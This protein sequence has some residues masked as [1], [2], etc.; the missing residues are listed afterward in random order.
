MIRIAEDDLRPKL[1]QQMLWNGLHGTGRPHRHKHRRLHLLV[2]QVEHRTAALPMR[3][4]DAARSYA[5]QKT[6]PVILEGRNF[7]HLAVILRQVV[8]QLLRGA[9]QQR[10]PPLRSNLRKRR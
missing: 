9:A 8:E 10:M 6:H 2:R 7:H 1:L 3:G 5:E 4:R